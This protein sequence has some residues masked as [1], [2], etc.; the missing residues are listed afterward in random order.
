MVDEEVKI[1]EIEE[2]DLIRML[3]TLEDAG[4]KID[5]EWNYDDGIRCLVEDMRGKYHVQ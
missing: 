3:D 2:R 4:G 5:S 1:I